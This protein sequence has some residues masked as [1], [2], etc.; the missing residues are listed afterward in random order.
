MKKK[1]LVV[2]REAKNT[3]R[4]HPLSPEELEEATGG[5]TQSPTEPAPAPT[6]HQDVARDW[7][8]W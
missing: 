3:K 6:V 4:L 8:W 1:K 2:L 5:V 7:G